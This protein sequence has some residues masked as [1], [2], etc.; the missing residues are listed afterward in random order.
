MHLVINLRYMKIIY[1]IK[2]IRQNENK[3]FF[4]SFKHKNLK[5]DFN[6]DNKF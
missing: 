5:R 4:H 1:V 2:L 3:R 6:Y